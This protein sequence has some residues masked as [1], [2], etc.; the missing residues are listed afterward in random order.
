MLTRLAVAVTRSDEDT[1]KEDRSYE[2][3]IADSSNLLDRIAA[4]LLQFHRQQRLFP[5][6][7]QRHGAGGRQRMGL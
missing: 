3:F 7:K 1:T 6:V 4:E 2:T 5:G